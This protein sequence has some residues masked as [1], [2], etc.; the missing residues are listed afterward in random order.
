VVEEHRVRQLQWEE[1]CPP[2]SMLKAALKPQD[3]VAFENRAF[4]RIFKAK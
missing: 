3:M 2:I 1:L 4:K